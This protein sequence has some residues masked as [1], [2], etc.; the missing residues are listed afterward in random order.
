MIKPDMINA[1]NPARDRAALA[2]E[3]VFVLL[4]ISSV[5]L[6]MANIASPL[7]EA[8]PFRQTQTA[9]TIWTFVTEGISFFSYQTPVFGPP[10]QAPF[11]FPAFQAVA[12]LMVKAGLQNIDVAARMANIVFFYLSA[13]FLFLLSGRFFREQGIA[14]TVVLCYV[15]S[16][17]TIFWSRTSM[18]DYASVSFAL[19]YFYF[20][21]RLIEEKGG[22]LISA[23]TIVCG[24][25]GYL[26]KITTMPTVVIPLAYLIIKQLRIDYKACEECGIFSYIAA[27]KIFFAKLL[28]AIVIPFAAGYLWTVHTDNVKGASLF[29]QWLVSANLEDWNYGT[30]AQRGSL[31]NWT[32]IYG[33]VKPFAPLLFVIVPVGLVFALWHPARYRAFIYTSSIGAFLTVFIFFNL[34]KSHNY[35]PMAITPFLALVVGFAVYH[36][37]FVLLKRIKSQASSLVKGVSD[38]WRK[39]L[40]AAVCAVCL[41][42]LGYL[43]IDGAIAYLKPPLIQNKYDKY[44]LSGFLRGITAP[45]EYIIITDHLWNPSILYYARRKGFMVNKDYDY[46]ARGLSFLKEHNFTTIITVRDYPELL[47]NW[48]YALRISP[49]GFHIAGYNIYKVTDDPKIFEDFKKLNE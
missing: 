24:A 38:P 44:T 5:I 42:S 45:N 26:V 8:H 25:L 49:P 11:E 1:N 23:A 48:R 4:V 9:I 29:T 12:A 30:W 41:I 17:Y 39:G 13:F 46:G 19:G 28:T 37:F 2:V 33:H 15:L 6:R 16:P 32:A 43:Y 40:I 31:A 20:F 22:W 18:I 7:F 14:Y 35:Y 47:S 34:Y 21:S 3:I 36:L 10:W 27:E